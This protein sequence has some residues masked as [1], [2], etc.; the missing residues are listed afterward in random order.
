[1][2][3]IKT[4]PLVDADDKLIKAL[5]AQQRLYPPEYRMPA[6]GEGGA[7]GDR[8]S[9]VMAHSLMPEVLQQTFL[10]FG[11]VISSDLPLSRRDHELIATAASATN[12][13]SYCADSHADFLQQVTSDDKL[14]KA[15]RNDYKTAELTD[16]ER[17]MVEYAVKLTRDSVS[18]Q[19]VD[20]E[21]LQAAGFSDKEI[22]QINLITAWF[23][24][25]NRVVNG[26]GVGRS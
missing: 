1:M 20:I 3:W 25:F 11:S 2:V 4:V 22:L 13:C 6:P 16:K 23:N 17:V 10:A 12:N 19:Q 24:Y 18:I 26:L 14:A 15:I 21:K 5:E 9:V 8:P 7:N